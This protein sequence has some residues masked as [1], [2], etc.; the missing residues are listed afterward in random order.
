[1]GILIGVRLLLDGIA[2][3]AAGF[4]ARSVMKSFA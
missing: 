2:L 3:L 4:A 1:V